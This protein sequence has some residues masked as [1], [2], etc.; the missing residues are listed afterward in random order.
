LTYKNKFGIA[1]LAAS[2][3]QSWLQYAIPL[4][5]VLGATGLGLGIGQGYWVLAVATVLV[6]LLLFYPIQLGVGFYA[7][8]L[9]FDAIAV[10][11]QA[12]KGRTLTWFAGAAAIAI[13]AGCG[14]ASRRLKSPPA[15]ATW[16]ILFTAWS[17][18]TAVW[19]LNPE[20]SL[21]ELP[22]TLAVL[23]LYLA[24]S[25]FR[26]TKKELQGVAYLAILGGCCAAV[27]SGYLY[28]QGSYFETGVE[29]RASLIVAGR[30]ANPDGLAMALLLP[31][32]L[33]L[34]YFLSRKRGLVKTCMMAALAATTLGLFLTMSRGAVVSLIVLVS[35]Y[36]YRLKAGVRLFVPIGLLALL[37]TLMPAG[38]FHRFQQA[39][40][41]GGSG[42]LD[43]WT[44]G[45]TAFKHYGLV[46]AGFSNFPF[47]YT[48][49]AGEARNFQGSYRDPHNIY[50]R[51]GVELGLVGLVLFVLAMRSQ[52]RAIP[53]SS[54]RSG[55]DHFRLAARAA[56]W[57]LLTFG[58][59]GN[60]LWSKE[61]WFALMLLSA[62]SALEDVLEP[63][64]SGGAGIDRGSV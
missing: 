33:A 12:Q 14:L 19:A 16:W 27:W 35:V 46:G 26:F 48:N 10:L 34:G 20:T 17:A 40:S 58:L 18:M 9:P 42:R 24:S 15:A 53:K 51:I 3:S 6:P 22:S 50:L 41:S 59:F 30:A 11:G 29:T 54:Q 23:A 37:L 25:C 57:G 39:G 44:V 36:I 8:L 63:E 5:A 21:E 4:L 56:A 64:L 28:Q 52:F 2:S 62:A 49:Y 32:S 13:L 45:L 43:I 60:I 1:T 38:F 47:A 7:L 61:L 31:I 55:V